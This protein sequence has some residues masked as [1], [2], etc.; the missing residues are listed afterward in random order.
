MKPQVCSEDQQYLRTHPWLAH[1]KIVLSDRSTPP[2]D[3]SWLV[4]HALS[5]QR[6]RG[7]GQM[8]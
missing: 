4:R 2:S 6:V 3:G 5:L 8:G 7:G 1:G